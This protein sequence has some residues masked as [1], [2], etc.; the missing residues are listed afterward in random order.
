MDHSTRQ[1]PLESGRR[2]SLNVNLDPEIIVE[3][4]KIGGGNRSKAIEQL[5]REHI[6]RTAEPA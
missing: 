4:A 5:V 2:I 6:A 1:E 3:L